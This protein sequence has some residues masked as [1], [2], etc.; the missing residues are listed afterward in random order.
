MPRV[1]VSPSRG[2]VYSRPLGLLCVGKAG[3]YFALVAS[4]SFD[5][6]QKVPL[7]VR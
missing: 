3:K 4:V 2:M 5:S 7:G 1:G 6:T